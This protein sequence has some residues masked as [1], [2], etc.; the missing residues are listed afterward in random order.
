MRLAPV[1]VGRG[2]ETAAQR[3]GRPRN[4][5][6]KTPMAPSVCWESPSRNIGCVRPGP[7]TIISANGRGS[8]DQD[9][10]VGGSRRSIPSYRP[11]EAQTSD[12]KQVQEQVERQLSA[13]Q[14]TVAS[15]GG[16]H[17]KNV[18]LVTPPSGV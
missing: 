18:G 6:L 13:G 4:E 1:G 14:T 11:K 10:N 12:P 5:S 17:W 8:A 9:V 3:P 7:Q 16:E 15:V 2:R